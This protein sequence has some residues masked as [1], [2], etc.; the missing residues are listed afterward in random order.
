MGLIRRRSKHHR[1]DRNR[2]SINNLQR[3]RLLFEELETR[4]MLSGSTLTLDPATQIS[5]KTFTTP[6]GTYLYV[7]LNAS[8]SDSSASVTYSVT[9]S[10]S[11]LTPVIMQN[12]VSGQTVSTLQLNVSGETGSSNTSFS[13]TIDIQLFGSITP[14]TVAQIESLVTSGFYTNEGNEFF[15]VTDLTGSGFD[16]AQGGSPSNNG[17]GGG[18]NPIFDEYSPELLFND[19][20]G[21]VAMA[22]SGHNTDN[23]QFFLTYGDAGGYQSQGDYSYTI[24]GQITSGFATVADIMNTNVSSTNDAPTSPITITSATIVQDNQNAV[25]QIFVPSGYTSSSTITVNATDSDGTAAPQVQF[26]VTGTADTVADTPFFTTPFGQSAPFTL[27][28]GSTTPTL[29]T[30]ED[31]STTFTVPVTNTNV[32]ATLEPSLMELDSSTGD[33]VAATDATATYYYDATSSTTGEL[34]VT[35]TPKSG[36]NSTA[37]LQLQLNDQLAAGDTATPNSGGPDYENFTLAIS[38]DPQVTTDVEL[39]TSFGQTSVITSSLLNTTDASGIT[40]ADLTYTLATI[41]ADGNLDLN[42]VPLAVGGQFTQADIDDGGL[43]FVN[44]GSTATTDDFTF[45]VA[46]TNGNTSPQATYAIQINTSDV[47]PTLAANNT[48]TL[49]QGNTATITTSL[50]QVTDSDKQD[51]QLTYTLTTLP[52]NG[53]LNLNGATLAAGGTFTQADIDEGHL[54]YTSTGGTSDSFQFNVSDDDGGSIGTT[55][56]SITDNASTPSVKTNTGL[57]ATVSTTSTITTAMLDTTDT[58][59]YPTSDLT[60]TLSS[61]PAD[62]Q[63]E[64]NGR[65]LAIGNTFNQYEIDQ[66]EL[67]FVSGTTTGSDSFQ[68]SVSDPGGNSTA[69]TTF[70]ITINAATP[71]PTVTTNTGLSIGPDATATITSSELQVTDSGVSNSQII[72]TVNSAPTGGT[73]YD[74]GVALASGQT[75]TQA[76]LDGGDLTYTNTSGTSDSFQFTASNDAGGATSETGFTI[77]VSAAPAAP[78]SITLDSNSNTGGFANFNY[79]SDDTPQIDITAAAGDTVTV[80]VNG[81]TITATGG[82]SGSYTATLPAG[83][84]AVGANSIT[85]TV[86]A[87]GVASS[88]S[89]ALSVTYAPNFAEVYTVPGTPGTA[90]TLDV[91]WVSRSAAYNDEIGWFTVSSLSGT[92]DGIAPGASGYAQAAITSTSQVI[93]PSGDQ[94][95]ESATLSVTGGQLIVFYMVQNASTSSFLSNNSSDSISGSPLIFFTATAANP[96][97]FQHVQVIQNQTTGQ[98]QYNWE[99][100][101]YGG[102]TDFNDVVMTVALAGTPS[103]VGALQVPGGGSGNTENIGAMLLG[104]TSLSSAPGDIGF[105][106][107]SDA[108]GDVGGVAPGSPGYAAAALAAGNYQ[109]LFGPGAGIGNV[110]SEAAPAGETI[111]FFAISSGTTANFLST[112]PNNSSSG[113]SVAFFSFTAANP[114]GTDHFRFTSPEG[115]A[116]NPSQVTLH[117]M[118]QLFGNDND[119]DSLAMSLSMSNG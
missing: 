37:N 46:D 24:F 31:T 13:G 54:S 36:F 33:Y 57:T 78:T 32:G 48:L 52:S 83:D 59:A 17:E 64:E 72:Y 40:P 12:G 85:A 107:V 74:S 80:L 102:D 14:N 112:N 92:V 62:G 49:T 93:F 106:Y 79:T 10:D 23:S 91:D 26:T 35:I 66:G 111:A 117:L 115:V 7:P 118:D 77:T 55:T 71:Y 82:S 75:F 6:D 29:T 103:N 105:Y 45:T 68:F 84:L 69:A 88:A 15:R 22:D 113:G 101:T 67:T 16:I 95:G 99:D 104:D 5:G 87:N 20:P 53:T 98:V 81:K 27:A 41:P 38:A 58:G 86:T 34:T 2:Q 1:S 8:E 119:Y 4:N 3:R 42:G 70:D 60:Y 108:S 47:G 50:L 11:T 43:T 110:A 18:A 65:V 90:E 56:F 76:D 114:D 89:S 28:S 25:L 30:Q 96:D 21:L 100:M 63:L 94:G 39:S 97:G 109:V 9:S 51:A 73:L 44:T 19:S 61:I 116:T